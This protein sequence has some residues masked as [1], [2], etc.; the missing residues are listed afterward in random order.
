MCR[1]GCGSDYPRCPT[2]ARRA[3]GP[4]LYAARSLQLAVLRRTRPRDVRTS[5]WM[6][7][8][9]QSGI[10]AEVGEATAPIACKPLHQ[11]DILRNSVP[12]KI[13]TK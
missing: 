4:L 13:E 1:G 7:L 11:G 3:P 5:S 9:H 8:G 6:T 12:D 2:G 10:P